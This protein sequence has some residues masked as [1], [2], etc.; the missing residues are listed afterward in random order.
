[1]LCIDFYTY[2]P[3]RVLYGAARGLWP[4]C[5]SLELDGTGGDGSLCGTALGIAIIG[6]RHSG[7]ELQTAQI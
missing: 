3:A 5:W 1:M 7:T 2:P 4:L 6:F